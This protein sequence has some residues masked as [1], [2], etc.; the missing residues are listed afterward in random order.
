MII[1]NATENDLSKMAFLMLQLGYPTT[2]E[3]MAARFKRIQL[4]N[5]HNTL[6]AEDQGEIIGM[7]GAFKQFTYE[8]DHLVVRIIVFIVDENHRRSGV[9]QRLIN[10][11]EDWAI[12]QGAVALTLTS[13]NRP[14]RIAAHQFY[15]R[16]GYIPKSTGFSKLMPSTD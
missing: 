6:L 9:G 5:N 14:E 3:A 10:A 1:R 8:F 13:G 7:A 11:V 15:T 16:C 2:T 12:E 4:D